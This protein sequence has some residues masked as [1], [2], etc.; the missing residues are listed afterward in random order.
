MSAIAFQC[1]RFSKVECLLS[2]C[3]RLLSLFDL[4]PSSPRVGRRGRQWRCC[5][6]SRRARHAWGSRHETSPDTTPRHF[7]ACHGNPNCSKP[8]DRPGV[9]CPPHC[10]STKRPTRGDHAFAGH[11]YRWESPRGGSEIAKF[12]IV[13]SAGKVLIHH[14]SDK[15]PMGIQSAMGN[16]GRG[17]A[18]PRG[19]GPE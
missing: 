8:F 10:R 2:L 3:Y 13:I 7:P 1:Y 16:C 5:N 11:E 15:S 19:L 18:M 12:R 14:D 4:L 9:W 17:D 6:N